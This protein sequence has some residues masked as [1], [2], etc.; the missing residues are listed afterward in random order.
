[1]HKTTQAYKYLAISYLP[2]FG[3]KTWFQSLY[4]SDLPEGLW[5]ENTME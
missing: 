1:M 4:L 2:G 3:Y 5:N